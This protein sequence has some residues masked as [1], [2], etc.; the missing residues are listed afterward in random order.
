MKRNIQHTQTNNTQQQ[1]FVNA[2]IK[3]GRQEEGNSDTS[4]LTLHLKSLEQ[5]EEIISKRS[6]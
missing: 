5:N 3:K 2:Y 6:S 1:W 4:N